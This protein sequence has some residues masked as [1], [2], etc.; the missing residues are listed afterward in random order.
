[1]RQADVVIDVM[2][3]GIGMARTWQQGRPTCLH[4]PSALRTGHR[5]GLELYSGTV[6]CASQ[7]SGKGRIFTERLP[8]LDGHELARRLRAQPATSRSVLISLTGYSQEKI[9]RE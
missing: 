9:S 2:D 4:K 6:S 3:D 8:R 1:V 5:E 7:G